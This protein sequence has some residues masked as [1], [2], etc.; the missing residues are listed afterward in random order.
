MKISIVIATAPDRNAE[1][2]ESLKKVDY[3][4]ERDEVIVV[5]GLNPS[6]NRNNSV[7]K[8]K[9]EII[10]FIDDDAFVDKNILKNAELF[11]ERHKE[12]SLIGGPQLTPKEDRT[13]AR[14]SGYALESY[15]G[16]SSMS[17]RYRIGKLDLNADE[18]SLTSANCFVRKDVFKKINGF[19][20]NLYPGEDPEFFAR[21][22][23]N[24]FRTA[25]VPNVIIYHK[26]RATLKK[27][28]EQ[29]FKYGYFRLKK[30]KFMGTRPGLLFFMPSFF[31]IYLLLLPI[32]AMASSIFLAPLMIYALAHLLVS[33]HIGI[34]K[35]DLL[36]LILL[37]FIFLLLHLSYGFGMIYHITTVNLHR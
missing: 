12:I 35:L 21:A 8:A 16:T 27:F 31:I 14:V 9:G 10:G 28:V 33:L 34:R 20:V 11:F 5:K 36:A 15:F 6:E 24:G 23:K 26:R 18:N 2:L 7:K 30:E 3:G 13:F 19:N 32:L 37:P 4:R 1:V 22:K 29:F 25:Y 17:K